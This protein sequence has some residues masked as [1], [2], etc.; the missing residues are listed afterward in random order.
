MPELKRGFHQIFDKIWR[1]LQIENS[2]HKG[3]TA[4]SVEYTADSLLEI[5]EC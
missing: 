1:A 4:T 5:E 2:S 3:N